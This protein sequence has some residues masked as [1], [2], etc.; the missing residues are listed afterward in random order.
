MN[1]KAEDSNDDISPCFS[2]SFQ[3]PE[4]TESNDD[5][6]LGLFHSLR[7]PKQQLVMTTSPQVSQIL[8]E[9]LLSALWLPDVE[10]RNLKSFE[11]LSVL[12]KARVSKK[13]LYKSSEV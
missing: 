2:E 5:N 1:S 4:T 11:S 8:F 12:S 9:S 13:N 3:L 6:L 10:I 7:T